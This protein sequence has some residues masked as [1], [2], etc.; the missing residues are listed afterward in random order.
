V[1]ENEEEILIVTNYHVVQG[2][3]T[4]N[5]QFVD[6]SV[7]EA[8]VKGSKPN[9]DLAVVAVRLDDLSA[10]TLN[11]IAIATLGDSDIL[12]VGE[13]AIAIG[14][15][16]G[17][18][19]SVTTGVISATN[20][21]TSYYTGGYGMGGYQIEGN[22]IQTDA[23]INP[24]NSGGALL[25]IKGEVIG[26]N[27]SKIGGSTIEGMGYAIPIS[28][29]KPIIAELMA[30]ETRARVSQANQGFIGISGLTIG[31]EISDLYGLPKGVYINRV[32]E[33]TAAEKY[34]INESDII[35][36]FD[37]HEIDSWEELLK[38]IAYY[39]AG[40]EV[41]LTLLRGDAFGGYTEITIDLILDAERPRN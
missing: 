12:K 20:R 7:A 29:A 37:T 17:Y 3:N 41:R 30:Q 13:P 14:N 10:E 28:A 16:M 23:A 32:H 8:L 4:L 18:G 9:M 11:S 22:F 34:G 40:E 33:G 26:I 15:A 1:G 35:I 19:Q 21:E 2:A 38:V 25:N 6:G 31:D 39:G 24:G 27:S 5:I 36:R